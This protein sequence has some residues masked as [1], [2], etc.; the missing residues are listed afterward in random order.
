MKT[1]KERLLYKILKN[2][3]ERGLTQQEIALK[4]NISRIKVSRFINKALADKIVQIKVN[5]PNDPASEIEQKLEE[6]YGLSEAVVVNV[7]S[8]N[9]LDELGEAVA[10]YLSLRIQGN[11][12][13]GVTWGRS[14]LAAVKAL[15][16]FNYPNI[17]IVQ[18]L[19]GLGNADSD[20]HG[21]E[22]VIQMA[23]AFK[24]R[25]RI[26]NSPGIV[27]SKDICMALLDNA[28]I[29][30]TLKLAENAD[31]ALVGIGALTDE[32]LIMQESK[33][34]K[35][36]EVRRLIRKGAVGNI[37]LRF[38]DKNGNQI[39]DEINERVV[40]LNCNQMKKIPRVIGIAAGIEKHITV[41]AALRGKCVN[42]LITDN[43]TAKF[44]ISESNKK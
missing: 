31:I 5:L 44:L 39:Q 37:G 6:I 21:T 17:R 26:L 9:I 30:D 11:E 12:T 22:L 34:I 19:G 15:P 43:Q 33:I 38:F 18:M 2:Y 28:Q 20:T 8:K 1:E 7:T 41:M 4:Y 32:A 36:D 13:I 35:D 10:D 14:I 42:T 29:T 40:G 24:A 25:V 16:V 23:K 3:Y 27:E